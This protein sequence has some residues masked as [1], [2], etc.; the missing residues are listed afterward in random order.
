MLERLTEVEGTVLDRD[1]YLSDFWQRATD[2]GGLFW[3]FE[4]RQTFSEP[5]NPSWT[6]MERGDDE[7]AVRLAEASWPAMVEQMTTEPFEEPRRVRVIEE[8]F[9]PY[10]RWQLFRLTQWARLGEKV[11][12]LPAATIRPLEPAGTLPEVTVIAGQVAYEV[13][14]DERG[15]L[16]GARRFTD[17][18]VVEACVNEIEALWEKAEDLAAFTARRPDGALAT[19]LGTGNALK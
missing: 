4:R 19:S 5:D 14:Y 18:D 13:L 16:T 11:R 15:S 2:L 9:T 3:K 8:P 10:I 6:A 17:G 12:L 7:E 1:T